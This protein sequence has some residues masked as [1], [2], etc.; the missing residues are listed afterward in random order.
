M[1]K[2]TKEST[3]KGCNLHEVCLRDYTRENDVGSCPCSTCLIK[4]ICK[5][6]CDDYID[7]RAQMRKP[8]L[9]PRNQNGK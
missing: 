5:K 3:C 9:L 7:F 2:P 8:Y 6:A 4:M 1:N